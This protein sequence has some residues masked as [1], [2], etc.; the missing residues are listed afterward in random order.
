MCVKIFMSQKGIHRS[1]TVM[2]AEGQCGAKEHAKFIYPSYRN[3][4]VEGVN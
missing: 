1:V 2:Q 4:D 3:I